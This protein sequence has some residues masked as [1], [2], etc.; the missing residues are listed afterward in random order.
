MKKI[1]LKYYYDEKNIV[2]CDYGIAWDMLYLGPIYPFKKKNIKLGILI[3]FLQLSIIALFIASFKIKLGILISAIM[4][5][6]INFLFAL[7]YN[8][9]VIERLL[10]IGYVPYDYNASNELIKKGIYFKLQ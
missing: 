10:K 3:L 2:E 9:I 8:M 5:L 4:M 6:L 7:N 1:Y